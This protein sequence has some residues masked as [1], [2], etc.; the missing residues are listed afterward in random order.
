MDGLL[1][2]FR[3][4]C[5]SSIPGAAV[6][7]TGNW[8]TAVWRIRG[9]TES[10]GTSHSLGSFNKRWENVNR[11]CLSSVVIQ[12]TA[13]M[14]HALTWDLHIHTAIFIINQGSAV[15][16]IGSVMKYVRWLQGACSLVA[17]QKE[18]VYIIISVRWMAAKPEC[19][20]LLL[21]MHS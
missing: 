8:K 15:E 20:Y 6:L 16:R 4:S 11:A 3:Y 7:Q 17:V 18:D 5:K 2:A 19:T 13:Q 10:G 9:R 1:T 21:H 12:S 14:L